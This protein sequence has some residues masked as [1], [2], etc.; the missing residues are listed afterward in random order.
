MPS[1]QQERDTS[2][3]RCPDT[4]PASCAFLRIAP[5]RA[6]PSAPI[7]SNKYVDRQGRA[8]SPLYLH[9]PG[10]L[11]PHPEPGGHLADSHRYLSEHRHPGDRGG[12]A[13]H[14]PQPGGDGRSDHHRFRASPDDDGG[15]HRAHRVDDG[16]RPVDGQDLSAAERAPR[17]GQRPGDGDRADRPPPAPA[18]RPAAADHQLQ[19]VDGADSPARPVRPLRVRAQR[20]RPQLLADPARHGS[21]RVHPVPVWRQAAPGDGRSG[22]APAPVEGALPGRR[23]HRPRPAE[24]RAAVRHRQDRPVR[25]RRRD[26]RQPPDR[27]RAERPPGQDGRQLD[28]LSAG[29]RPRARRV[30]APDEHRPSGRPPGRA[31]HDSQDGHGVHPR[32]RAR[33]PAISCPA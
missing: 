16:E 20:R 31:R 22:P 12:L 6:V 33:H 18:R 4:A 3:G 9:R 13:V 17:H 21:G 25:V 28:D 15:Q 30:R 8:Q 14:R 1:F 24:H 23:R 19:R 26:E 11:D 5:P 32:R 10:A 7:A 2:R 27:G 29:R